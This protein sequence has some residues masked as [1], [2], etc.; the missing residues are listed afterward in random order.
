MSLLPRQL[1]GL[2]LALPTWTG[3]RLVPHPAG[4]HRAAELHVVCVPRRTVT[5]GDGAEPRRAAGS[6]SRAGLQHVQPPEA[7]L[8]RRHTHRG[9]EQTQREQQAAYNPSH[10]HTEH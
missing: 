5:R 6:G 7:A 3:V 8:L 4:P 9:E 1:H 2:L 10:I